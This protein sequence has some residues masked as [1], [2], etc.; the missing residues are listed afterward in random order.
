MD[1]HLRIN[2]N[3]TQQ[4]GSL[5]LVMRTQQG[6]KSAQRKLEELF[7]RVSQ[8][9]LGGGFRVFQCWLR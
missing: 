9:A 4:G 6:A 5:V 3:I 7:P 8:I 2:S 1:I